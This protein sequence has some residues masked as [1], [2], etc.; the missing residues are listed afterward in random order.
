MAFMN[1]KTVWE[2]EWEVLR[3]KEERFLKKQS[4]DIPSLLDKK[5]KEIVPPSLQEKLDLAFAKA[6]QLVFEKGTGVIEKTYNKG[7]WEDQYKIHEFT[8]D[9][10]QNRR[11][12]KAF[13]K[14]AD[15]TRTKNLLVSGVEGIGL[16]ILGIGIPDIPLFAG[17]LL[18]SVYEIAISYGYAYDTKEEQILILRMIRTALAHGEELA[19]EN[20]AVD[21][22][23][24]SRTEARGDW[25]EEIRKTSEALAKELLYMKFL[26]GIPVAGIVGGISDAVCLKKVT[27]YVAFKYQ[28]RFLLKKKKGSTGNQPK[29]LDNYP[30][31]L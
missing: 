2:K 30:E 14:Q 20:Q 17:M 16:G 22:T 25:S 15:K 19:Q 26:Q 6:F 7:R 21:L 29:S 1:S 4:S 18:K 31:K 28:R 23:L 8:A 10:K 13:S 3:R 5:L 12:M 27:D 11:S 24:A 9:L